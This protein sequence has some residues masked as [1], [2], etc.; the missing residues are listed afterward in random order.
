MHGIPRPPRFVK[1]KENERSPRPHRFVKIE[2][3]SREEKSENTFTSSTQIS[4]LGVHSPTVNRRQSVAETMEGARIIRAAASIFFCLEQV[5]KLRQRGRRSRK[6]SI[7]ELRT[8]TLFSL[9]AKILSTSGFSL[10]Y[11]YS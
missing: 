9:P 10:A 3:E 7:L 5:C 6:S 8:E 2:S 4:L 11:L 1:K